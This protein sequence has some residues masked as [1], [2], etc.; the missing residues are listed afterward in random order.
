MERFSIKS[1]PM[2]KVSTIIEI[3]DRW[4]SRKAVADDLGVSPARVHKWPSS[5]S[6]PAKYHLGLIEAAARRGISLTAD[7]LVRAHSDPRALDRLRLLSQLSPP[8]ED[9]A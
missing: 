5:N 4:G 2:E 9:A 3:L 8:S 6:I 7:E 1:R